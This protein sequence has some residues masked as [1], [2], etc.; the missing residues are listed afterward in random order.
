MALTRLTIDGYGQVE[1]NNFAALRDGRVEAQC[2]LSATDF[3]KGAENGMLVAVDKATKQIKLYNA[4]KDYPLAMIYSSE[5]LYTDNTGMKDFIN[6]VNG[7]YPRLGYLAVGDL[8]TLNTFCYDT[9]EYATEDKVKTALAALALT[10]VYA[11]VT[12]TGAWKITAT[13]PTAGPIA[14][15]TKTTTM[16]DGQFG[17]QIQIVAD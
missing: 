11:G 3:P 5:H 15:V 9:T 8:F 4:A 1:L 13:K 16:P 2:K 7:A 6:E 14:L 12:N 17:I 10:P